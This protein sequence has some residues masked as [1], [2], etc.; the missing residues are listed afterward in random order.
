ML[1]GGHY[2]GGH[3]PSEVG[4]SGSLNHET[5]E[6]LDKRHLGVKGSLACKPVSLWEV[7]GGGQML[8]RIH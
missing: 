1:W 8:N 6:Q 2:G 4:G 7:L 5:M 3:I